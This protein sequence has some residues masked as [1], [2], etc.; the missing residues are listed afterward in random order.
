MTGYR[1]LPPYRPTRP[2]KLAQQYNSIIRN[3]AGALAQASY[4]SNIV[5]ASYR[6]GELDG[7]D[8]TAMCLSLDN[9][10]LACRKLKHQA[11]ITRDQAI[12]SARDKEPKVK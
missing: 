5:N 8:Y 11:G 6:A 10:R 9:F 2:R 12:A 7:V 4:I 3:V 1:V